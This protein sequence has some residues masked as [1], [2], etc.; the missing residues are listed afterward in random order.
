MACELTTWMLLLALDGPA[1][2]WEPQ[3]LRLFSP[4]GR[5]V[6]GGRRLRL[7][8]AATGPGPPS[9]PPRSPACAPSHQAD[10]HQTAPT[11]E[12]TNPRARGTPPTRRDSQAASHSHP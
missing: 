12:R 10:Q 2:A 3:R 7:R 4:A 1:R 5:I 6:R 8:I 11:P 9:T